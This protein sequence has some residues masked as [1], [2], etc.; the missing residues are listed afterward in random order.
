MVVCA[1]IVG[2]W[3]PAGGIVM[4]WVHSTSVACPTQRKPTQHKRSWYGIGV[5]SSFAY[6]TECSTRIDSS[7]IPVSL[8]LRRKTYLLT[9]LSPAL[10]YERPTQLVFHDA[11]PFHVGADFVT[12]THCT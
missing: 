12:C 9:M 10:N 3:W 6:G 8:A 1:Y 4:L 7:S 2:S 11:T 5:Y